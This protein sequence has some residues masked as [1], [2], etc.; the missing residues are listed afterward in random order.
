MAKIRKDGGSSVVA[1]API[2]LKIAGF[3]CGDI[4][5]IEAV[6]GAI[7]IKKL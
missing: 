3:E 4:V 1:L 2:Y 7:T 5:K 6:D